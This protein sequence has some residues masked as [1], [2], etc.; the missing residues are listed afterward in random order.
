MFGDLTTL[1]ANG[2]AMGAAPSPGFHHSVK[3]S[4]EMVLR[5]VFGS[6][7]VRLCC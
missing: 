2:Y 5:A 3:G 1:Q 7:E 4:E 6:L